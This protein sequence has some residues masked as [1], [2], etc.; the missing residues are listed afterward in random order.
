MLYKNATNITT[1]NDEVTNVATVLA[2]VSAGS[3]GLPSNSTLNYIAN[4][5]TTSGDV[6]MGF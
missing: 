6:S 2:M 3:G 1:N 5:N 4:T